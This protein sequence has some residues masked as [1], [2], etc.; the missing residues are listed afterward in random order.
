MKKTALLVVDVQNLLVEHCYQ[1]QQIVERIKR[2]IAEARERELPVIYVQHHEADELVFGSPGWEIPASIKPEET[3][4]VVHK[5]APD[6][7]YETGLHDKLQSLS[8]EKLIVVGFQT[9]YCVDTTCRSAISLNYD[10]TLVSDCHST[11]DSPALKAADIIAHHNTTL[12]G[13]GTPQHTI[14]GKDSASVWEA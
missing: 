7:F 3:D 9:D 4:P 12:H 2:L 14:R 8:I 5:T 11:V 1:G 10:V 6:S 13:F